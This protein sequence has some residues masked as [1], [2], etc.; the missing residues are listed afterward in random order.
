MVLKMPL[1]QVQ[2]RERSD[3]TRKLD[4]MPR[5][6]SQAWVIQL[7]V[8]TVH[9]ML[10]GCWQLRRH[11]WCWFRQLLMERTDIRSQSQRKEEHLSAWL[12]CLKIWRNTRWLKLISKLPSLM[13]M[14]TC[15]KDVLSPVLGLIWSLG[16]WSMSWEVKPINMRLNVWMIISCQMNSDI[17]EMIT[18]WWLCLRIFVSKELDSIIKQADENEKSLLKRTKMF[19]CLKKNKA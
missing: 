9:W 17:R 18:C 5:H 14:R 11:I 12:S 4:K 15:Q 7:S 3:F 10:N 13:I 2:T 6:Y 1:Q 16:T 8:W 19:C